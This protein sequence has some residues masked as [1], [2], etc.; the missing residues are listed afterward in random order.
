MRTEGTTII[1]VIPTWFLVLNTFLILVIIGLFI[2]LMMV[3]LALVKVVK[4]LEPKVNKLV[5]QVNEDVIPQV[6]GV[7]TKVDTISSNIQG[8]TGS[9]SN[10]MGL[11]RGKVESVGSTM[12]TLTNIGMQ[13]A[14]KLGPWI[15]YLMV[16]VKVYEMIATVRNARAKSNPTKKQS[17]STEIVRH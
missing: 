17:E 10:A 14:E 16:G 4:Q 3:S 8:L 5:D 2:G 13:K 9:A 1:E 11:V 6:K 15:G 12:E 7:V